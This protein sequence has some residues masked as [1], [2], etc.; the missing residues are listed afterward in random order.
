MLVNRTAAAQHLSFDSFCEDASPSESKPIRRFVEIP[1]QQQLL[2][3]IFRLWPLE[4]TGSEE[5]ERCV[6]CNRCIVIDTLHDE[7][8]CSF[9]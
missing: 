8:K 4:A 7:S 1:F 5:I 9:L 2:K 3:E 6:V